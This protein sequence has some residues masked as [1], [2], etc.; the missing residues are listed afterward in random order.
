MPLISTHDTTFPL[1]EGETLLEGLERTGHE[2]EYQCR[3]GYCG[4]CRV[5]IL[6]GRV[7]YA[8]LPLAFIAPGEILTCCCRV[9][10]NITI[11]CRKRIEEPDL[12]SGDLFDG[13]GS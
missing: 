8:D 6:S 13:N 4:F 5:R 7:S 12:F 3:S 9:T 10:E 1:Q 2:I 11:D